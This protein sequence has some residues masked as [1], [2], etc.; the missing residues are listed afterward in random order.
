MPPDFTDH[1]MHNTG[2]SQAE[3]DAVHGQGK[4]M[5][6][7]VPSL[8]Q[9][10]ANPNAYL[11]VT[12]QHPNAPEIFRMA[13]VASD[14]QKADLGVWNIF[15]NPDFTDRYASLRK[16]LCAIATHQF[17]DC[18]P[19]RRPVA[20][21]AVAVFR[22]RTLRDL[23]ESDPYMHNGQFNTLTDVMKFYQQ[24]GVLAR[25]GQLRNADPRMQNI[26]LND[27]DLADLAAFLASLN[28]DYSN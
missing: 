16:F 19:D 12:P 11:P 1:L 28:E 15:A 6:L 5:Q 24:T 2:V 22:T 10:N 18:A 13:P 8:A 26:A 3:Y 9:R 20:E 7:Q 21:P 23:G 25:T 14:P 17:A 27:A 4:F